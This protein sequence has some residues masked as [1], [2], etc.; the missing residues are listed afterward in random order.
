[1]RLLE[2]ELNPEVTDFLDSQT[3]PLR[4]EIEKI[5]SCIL[6]A[7]NQVTENIKWNGPN[8]SVNQ[9]DRITLRIHPPS[10]LQI[11]FH[12][13]AKKQEQPAQKLISV[14]HPFLSWKENDRA[15]MTFQTVEQIDENSSFLSEFAHQWI[16]ATQE[17]K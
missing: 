13:G 10:K 2:N 11:I 6:H 14:E 17:V 5:R 9:Q 1:M 7:H 15:V 16:E 4:N 8:Y 3:L 12:R